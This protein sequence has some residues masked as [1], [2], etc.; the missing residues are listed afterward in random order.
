M[1]ICD[2]TQFYSPVSGGVRRYVEQKV[3]YIRRERPD[4]QHILIVPGET[5]GMTGDET[6]RVYTIASP[7]ISRTSRYR[8]LLKLSMVEEVLES[9]KP[10]IICLLYT[11]PSPRD[12]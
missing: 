12:S 4:C 10:S 3:A 2:L 9:E 11:S 1:K 7:L 8:A 5:T 6:A